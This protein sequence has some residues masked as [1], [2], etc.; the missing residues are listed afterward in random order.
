MTTPRT[1]NQPFSAD[2][3]AIDDT[4]EY[5]GYVLRSVKAEGSWVK[6]FYVN[7]HQA[8]IEDDPSADEA[9]ID[10]MIR[11]EWGEFVRMY[12]AASERAGRTPAQD[13]ALSQR[14]DAEEAARKS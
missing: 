4:V 8:L 9:V 13:I 1:P 5:P 2:Y 10:F 6:P 3:P 12:K 11:T 14:E 7:L